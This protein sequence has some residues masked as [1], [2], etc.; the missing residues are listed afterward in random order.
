M[1][2]TT[3]SIRVPCA[4]A[5]MLVEAGLSFKYLD[6]VDQWTSEALPVK[7]Q[8]GSNDA[9]AAAHQ[10]R[11]QHVGEV[12]PVRAVVIGL[13]AV[14]NCSSCSDIQV[15]LHAVPAIDAS[16]LALMQQC[17]QRFQRRRG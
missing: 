14:L 12:L 7:L 9:L 16:M 15:L 4:L 2:S 5:D 17:L 11:L 10:L 1:Q 8:R 6:C 3:R 13:E